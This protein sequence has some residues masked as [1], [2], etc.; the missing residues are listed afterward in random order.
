MPEPI[1]QA[2]VGFERRTL[3]RLDRLRAVHGRSRSHLLE[4]LV[5]AALDI[6]EA[7]P[8]VSAALSR[9]RQLSKGAEMTL[10]EYTE[11]YVKTFGAKT[12]PP[13]VEQLEEIKFCQMEHKL[14]HDEVI[15]ELRGEPAAPGRHE[16]HVADLRDEEAGIADVPVLRT[17][18]DIRAQQEIDDRERR[19][20]N[21]L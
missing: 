8:D 1:V 3:L 20:A 15:A 17:L 12:F 9:F 11:R 13:T 16:Q 21:G 14:T 10:D 7:K 5:S 2:G 19:E 18:R 4:R 6:E